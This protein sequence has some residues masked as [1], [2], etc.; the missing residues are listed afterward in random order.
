MRGRSRRLWA[1]Y[2]GFVLKV[3]IVSENAKKL[4]IRGLGWTGLSELWFIGIRIGKKFRVK[5]FFWIAFL[6]NH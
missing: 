1:K 3:S 4:R 2:T 6:T 5:A